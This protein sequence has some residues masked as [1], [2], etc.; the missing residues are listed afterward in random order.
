MKFYRCFLI[1]F[2]AFGVIGG[3]WADEYC[4]G[5]NIWPC[6]GYENNRSVYCRL[7]E[8]NCSGISQCKKYEACQ[9]TGQYA[10]STW[11]V[12]GPSDICHVENGV[13]FEN[14]VPC[15][16]FDIDAA[17]G[18]WTCD[19]GA[20]SNDAY[21]KPAPTNAWDTSGCKCNV[22]DKDIDIDAGD[23]VIKCKKANAVYYVADVD[24]YRTK[25][26][27]DNVHYTP[28]RR[29]C[30]ECYPGKIPN[31][32]V[33]Q[34]DGIWNRPDNTGNWGAWR[35]GQDVY[36]PQYAD[37]CIIDFSIPNWEAAIGS[38]NCVKTCP[39]GFET[40]ENGAT[41]VGDCV[42]Q[43]S[44]TYEDSTGTF[45]LTSPLVSCP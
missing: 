19:K 20:Q 42:S 34:S 30:A 16:V 44:E 6:P 11:Y 21:W 25:K 4:N 28:E 2:G 14:T 33:A 5:Y 24:R 3:A 9:K 31:V 37:G 29:Y 26:V 15:S 39:T 22:V 10:G 41:S 36:K 7:I 32:I 17:Y 12:A 35:C 13:C 40:E 8:Q 27:S 23:T 43:Y 18:A 38:E 1:V 45:V